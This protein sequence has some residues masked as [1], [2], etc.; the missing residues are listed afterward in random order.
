MA[1]NSRPNP[2]QD[3]QPRLD[4]RYLD[5]TM[6]PDGMFFSLNEPLDGSLRE[7]PWCAATIQCKKRSGVQVVVCLFSV[8][9]LASCFDALLVPVSRRASLLPDTT[10]TGTLSPTRRLLA[11]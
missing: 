8:S 3:S 11:E 6:V 4:E 5:G 10:Q 1:A 9:A 2:R 7:R